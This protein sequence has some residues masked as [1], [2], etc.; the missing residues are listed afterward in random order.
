M[1]RTRLRARRREDD[2]IARQP[3]RR[4]AGP[5]LPHLRA[6]AHRR[7]RRC[8]PLGAHRPA[9]TASLPGHRPGP[10]RRRSGSAPRLPRPQ[11]LSRLS[12][13][14][15]HPHRGRD[16]HPVERHAQLSRPGRP[17]GHRR[18]RGLDRGR[19]RGRA[20][21][22]R[23]PVARRPAHRRDP[24]LHRRRG[25]LLGA[26][27]GTPLATARGGARGRIGFQ[28]RARRARRRRPQRP[29]RPRGH[30]PAGHRDHPAR[31]R[32]TRGGRRHRR[33]CR[34]ARRQGDEPARLHCLRP[35]P[36]RRH[37]LDAARLRPPP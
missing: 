24:Q 27:R 18:G 6:R 1:C 23:H 8:S 17:V 3:E 4:G 19:R 28:R 15:V 12:G 35:V 7:G 33:G 20:R 34:L 21:P 11:P 32:R 29:P 10:R 36:D 16:H 37:R 9:V 5:D 2:R 25:R 13:A 30:R 31:D 22:A 14:R 26:A